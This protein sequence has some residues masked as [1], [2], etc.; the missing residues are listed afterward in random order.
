[1]TVDEVAQLIR[2]SRRTVM[3]MVKDETLPQPT[4]FNPMSFDERAVRQA[5]KGE[6]RAPRSTKAKRKRR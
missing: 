3:R 1:M 5:V 6:N 4:A 2:R